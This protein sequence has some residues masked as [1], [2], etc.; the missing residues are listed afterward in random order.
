MAICD[1]VVDEE[2]R[3]ISDCGDKDEVEAEDDLEW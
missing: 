3:E 2:D 1:E